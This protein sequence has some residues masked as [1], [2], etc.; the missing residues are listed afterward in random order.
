MAEPSKPLMLSWRFAPLFWCQFFSAF[1]DNFLKNAIVFLILFHISAGTGQ[2]DAEYGEAL[3]TLAA[4]IFIAPY[5]ILSALGGQIAD[6]FDKARVLKF[7]KIAEAPI[8]ALGLF[9]LIEQSVP[10][11]LVA[12]FLMGAQSTFFSPAKYGLMPER[13]GIER[14]VPANAVLESA[15]FLSI[16]LGTI[17]GEHGVNIANFQL[18]RNKPGGDAIALLYLDAPFPESVLAELRA[19][20]KIASAVE[21]SSSRMRASRSS[22]SC[23]AAFSCVM[24]RTIAEQPATSPRAP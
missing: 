11:L 13:L 21:S 20:P 17:C 15:T 19:N 18:G 4:A 5:F 2:V 10:I 6:R 22:S 16:L 7:A 8:M 23:C 12:L 1:N 3:I 24:S 14:L 9:G